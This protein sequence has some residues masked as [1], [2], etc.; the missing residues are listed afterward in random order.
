MEGSFVFLMDLTSSSTTSSFSS[1]SSLLLNDVTGGRFCKLTTGES[2]DLARL[3]TEGDVGT[4]ADPSDSPN[5]ANKIGERS[6]LGAI[7]VELGSSENFFHCDSGLFTIFFATFA[8]G[9]LSDVGDLPVLLKSVLVSFSFPTL[10]F[11]DFGFSTLLSAAAVSS[12]FGLGAVLGLMSTFLSL[13]TTY[14]NISAFAIFCVSLA[15]G[16]VSSIF[17]SGSS[18]VCSSAFCVSFISSLSLSSVF[19]FLSLPSL[20]FLQASL[21]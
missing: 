18:L 19:S 5:L 12:D 16:L 8:V 1:V 7:R 17:P 2:S 6:L 9:D 14:F 10:I 21:E 13:L 3:D 15:L 20:S 4:Y 11:K